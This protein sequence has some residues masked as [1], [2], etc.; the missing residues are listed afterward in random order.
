MNLK[1]Q[2]QNFDSTLPPAYVP[3]GRREPRCPVR[4]LKRWPQLIRTMNRTTKL[5]YAKDLNIQGAE[6]MSPVELVQ[7][8]FQA[9]K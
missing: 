5:A 4:Q 3:A 9:L 6:S 2:C 7:A 8:L 1:Q